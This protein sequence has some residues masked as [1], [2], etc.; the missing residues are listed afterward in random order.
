LDV[1]GIIALIVAVLWCVGLLGDL[2]GDTIQKVRD[3]QQKV[4]RLDFSDSMHRAQLEMAR[5]VMEIMAKKILDQNARLELAEQDILS[6]KRAQS[7]D[8]LTLHDLEGEVADHLE[9]LIEDA[10][11]AAYLE[12]RVTA[13]EAKRTRKVA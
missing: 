10:I 9:M 1:A 3:F 4:E 6:L 11:D 12:E 13:L 7:E 8:S 2:I 5:M